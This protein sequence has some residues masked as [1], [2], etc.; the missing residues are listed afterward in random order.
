MKPDGKVGSVWGGSWAR[1]GWWW[2][3]WSRSEHTVSGDW[4]AHPH[5]KGFRVVRLKL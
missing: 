4:P 1:S 5:L 2:L 3:H